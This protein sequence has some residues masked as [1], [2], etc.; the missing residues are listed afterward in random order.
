MSEPGA[1]PIPLLGEIS[2]EYVQRVEHALDGGFRPMRIAGLAGTLQQRSGRP[3]H[4]I[5]IAGVLRGDTAADD[6]AAI[7]EAAAAGAE[8]TFAADIST[9]LELQHVVITSLRVVEAA[10][11][12]GQYGYEIGL[13]ESPPLPPPAQV[14]P[15]GGLG[16][17][18]MGDL[19]FDTDILGDLMDEASGLADAVS[20]AMDLLDQLGALA[21]LDGLELGSF[22]EPLQGSIDAV[23]GIASRLGDA[24]DGMLGGLT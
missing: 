5:W 19:G 14:E 15:F 24:L 2:L 23:T 18:G 1:R 21:N 11:H 9:A 7:Q 22:L 6:L 8:L 10:G 16:D 13:A 4:H 20:G 17:F 12:P 3:S